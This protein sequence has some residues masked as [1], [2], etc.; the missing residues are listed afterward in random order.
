MKD[1]S[2]CFGK[3]LR[4]TKQ[5][6]T[7]FYPGPVLPPSGEGYPLKE[8]EKQWSYFVKA[9]LRTKGRQQLSWLYYNGFNG[10]QPAG[11]LPRLAKVMTDIVIHFFAAKLFCVLRRCFIF[12]IISPHIGHWC[13]FSPH[14]A[15]FWTFLK[16]A[17]PPKHQLATDKTSTGN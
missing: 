10:R 6:E 2:Y 9:S 4:I 14:A 7:T 5:N 8:E 3:N 13:F 1:A 12:S 15:P 11:D 16:N 17:E